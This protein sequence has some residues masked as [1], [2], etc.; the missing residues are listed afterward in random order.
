MKNV[1]M[2]SSGCMNAFAY[3]YRRLIGI[4]FLNFVEYNLLFKIAARNCNFN[5]DPSSRKN[6]LSFIPTGP[7]PVSYS[8]Q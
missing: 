7:M 6:N 5:F 3:S 4:F 8:K 2:C 1:N